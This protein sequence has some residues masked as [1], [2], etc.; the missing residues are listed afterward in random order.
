MSSVQLTREGDYQQPPAPAQAILN[1]DIWNF[2]LGDIATRFA[3]LEAVNTGIAA[4]Q[5]ELQTFG[6]QRLNDAINPLITDAQN[7]LAQLETDIDAAIAQLNADVATAQ[8]AIDELLE[9]GVPADDVNENAS[10]VF[11]TPDQKT[12]IGTLR[13]N[14]DALAASVGALVV[15]PD[16][17]DQEGKVL[18]SKNGALAYT[19][20]AGGGGVASSMKNPF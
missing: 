11:V 2:V 15:V 7:T 19:G 3:S 4:L 20:A 13:T 16:P 6:V 18:T 14:L 8:T 12:E 5:A 10:R 17:T 9:G 1:R